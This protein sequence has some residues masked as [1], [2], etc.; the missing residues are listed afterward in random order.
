MKEHDIMKNNVIS[1]NEFKAMFLD[2]E[3]LDLVKAHKFENKPNSP[4][5]QTASWFPANF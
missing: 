1:Y 2:L 3:D 4:D 5:G